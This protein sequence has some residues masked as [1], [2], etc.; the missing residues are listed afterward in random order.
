M[1]KEDTL[2]RGLSAHIPIARVM[3][4]QSIKCL[5]ANSHKPVVFAIKMYIYFSVA[6]SYT[7]F[8]IHLPNAPIRWGN[9]V[10]RT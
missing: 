2:A 5:R 9:K 8:S 1:T 4:E 10:S 6:K 7:I 3:V